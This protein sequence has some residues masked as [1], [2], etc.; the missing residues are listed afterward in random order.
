MKPIDKFNKDK[1]QPNDYWCK[2][3]REKAIKK[4]TETVQK[5]IFIKDN[6]SSKV[7]KIM[8]FG[9]KKTRNPIII[10]NNNPYLKCK[11]DFCHNNIKL[12]NEFYADS[13][14]N[15]DVKN[16]CKYCMKKKRDKKGTH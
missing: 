1:Y 12:L 4:A 11:G 14:N 8:A 10:S 13:G 15:N 6:S 3:C 5:D 16:I 2:E 9:V 7:N